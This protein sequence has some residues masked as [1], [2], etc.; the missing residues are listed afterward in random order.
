MAGPAAAVPPASTL[1]SLADKEPSRPDR[2]VLI[3]LV[4]IAGSVGYRWY[5]DHYGMQPSQLIRDA[6]HR[7]DL[8]RASKA[9][10]QQVPGIGPQLADRI[11]AEREAT[12]QFKNVDDLHRV[13][14]IGDATLSKMKPW[15]VIHAVDEPRRDSLVTD[16]LK[17]KPVAKQAKAPGE[18]INL[19]SATMV[20][21]Q[22]L[23]NI[24]PVLA[25]RIIDERTK[26]PFTRVDD[27]DR[28][29]GIGVKRLTALWD[30]VSVE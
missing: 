13:H 28:V 29:S 9:E 17:R 24:G 10:L 22:T 18:R 3:L 8:N 1:P 12:G 25:Q 20:E 6:T 19:N 30:L 11:V 26:K 5:A 15:I 23:P 2:V 21:L 14:G 4:I 7:V 16:V 27:L